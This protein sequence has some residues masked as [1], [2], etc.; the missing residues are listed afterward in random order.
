MTD[1]KNKIILHG[2]PVGHDWSGNPTEEEK[3]YLKTFYDL[4]IQ[5]NKALIV[6]IIT[7]TSYYTFIRKNNV[8]NIEGRPGSYFGLTVCFE[9]VVCT[10]VY[11][12][13]QILDKIYSQICVG[14][15]VQD[16]NSKAQFQVRQ[17]SQAQVKGVNLVEYIGAVM[18]KQ[19]T[20]ILSTSFKFIEKDVI[21]RG[22]VRFSLQ[23]VDCPLFVDSSLTKQIL[24][25]AEIESAILSYNSVIEEL[26]T[27]RSNYNTLKSDYSNLKQNEQ[28]LTRKVDSLENETKQT[29]EKTKQS[30]EKKLSE[31]K[32]QLDSSQ[33]QLA[34]KEDLC[35]QLEGKMQQA[36]Q[37][38][39]AINLP[40]KE[41]TRLMAG[42]FP[43]SIPPVGE[44]S[45]KRPQILD[46]KHHQSIW[47]KVGYYVLLALILLL[48]ILIYLRVSTISAS[49]SASDN[50]V[51]ASIKLPDSTL[52]DSG[53]VS[54]E[55]QLESSD[56]ADKIDYGNYII[57]IQG[58][59][60]RTG[61]QKDK[62]Y[63]IR[64]LTQEG[65][66]PHPVPDSI[67][68]AGTWV[69]SRG[70][71]LINKNVIKND[72]KSNEN[73]DV[74]IYFVVNGNVKVTRS[75]KIN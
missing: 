63:T 51:V 25:S 71:S 32:A 64:L 58:Y 13:Y 74:F 34:A 18:E 69:V 72:N 28:L 17:V 40:L 75:L 15:I 23:D 19:I 44:E 49:D 22:L 35:K 60:R 6:D 39:N 48:T 73:V 52:E 10:N 50:K 20:S 46:K 41:L 11:V 1:I 27:V 29:K 57:D 65:T 5:E 43:N 62:Q 33:R 9:G 16:D 53:Q 21:T 37:Q 56:N 31:M 54:E 36:S 59:D 26:N 66:H 30:Y 3:S 2:V 12:L 42:R 47:N 4:K 24:V 67:S 7:K 14:T 55:I 61:L 70:L 38:V 8:S 68:C 45:P